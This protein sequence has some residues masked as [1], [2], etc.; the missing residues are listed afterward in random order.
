[1]SSHSA[2]ACADTHRE[3][4]TAV[5]A[6]S[7]N[8]FWCDPKEGEFYASVRIT[9]TV[10]ESVKAA[11]EEEAW[12]KIE[13]MIK[14]EGID[15]CGTDVD[16]T[17]IDYIYAERPMFLIHRPGTTVSGATSIQPGDEPREPKNGYERRTYTVPPKA[18]SASSVGTDGEA[19]SASK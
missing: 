3:A 14:A 15:V 12:K 6:L 2:S 4:E 7:P 18:T 10:H 1:M 17:R 11:S 5:V 8:E 13:D 9:A 16:E 19:G